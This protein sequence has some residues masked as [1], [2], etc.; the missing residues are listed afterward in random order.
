MMKARIR[1]IV[2]GSANPMDAQAEI[3]EALHAMLSDLLDQYDQ[4]VPEFGPFND[5]RV[6]RQ[7]AYGDPATTQPGTLELAVMSMDEQLNPDNRTLRFLAIRVKKSPRGGAVSS[8]CFHGTKAAVHAEMQREL[9]TPQLL[10][11]R[12]EE[13]ASGL[14]EE[15]NPGMWR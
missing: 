9:R 4:R 15:T 12:V 10:L 5:L 2:S 11:E 7:V 1:A 6:R 13:L 14:P 3:I 8:T